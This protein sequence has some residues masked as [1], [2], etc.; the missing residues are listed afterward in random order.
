MA[1]KVGFL[2]KVAD[3][4]ALIFGG[5]ITIRLEREFLHPQ[6][7]R[8]IVAQQFQVLGDSACQQVRLQDFVETL[9]GGHRGRFWS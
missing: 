6:L 1:A 2:P 4:D 9:P 3:E 5:E 8:G 7:R